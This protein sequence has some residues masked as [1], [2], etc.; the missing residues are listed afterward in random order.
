MLYLLC[1]WYIV[2]KAAFMLEI[3]SI[4]LLSLIL[5]AKVYLLCKNTFLKKRMML[6]LNIHPFFMSF[7][8]SFPLC[9]DARY[10]KVAHKK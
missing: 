1:R 5:H 2:L 7:C 4:Q 10:Q 6:M 9:K 8:F 3:Y